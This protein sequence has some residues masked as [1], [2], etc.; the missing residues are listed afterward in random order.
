MAREPISRRKT[1]P[2]GLVRPFV[3]EAGDFAARGG[4]ELLKANV[5]I[6]A[7]TVGASLDGVV[8]GDYPWRRR[9]GTQI[10]RILHS[11]NYRR[12][13]GESAAKIFLAEGIAEWEPRATIETSQTRIRRT[14]DNRVRLQIAFNEQE[15]LRGR[16]IAAGR[17]TDPAKTEVVV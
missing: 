11:N 5:R 12:T 2:F 16:D 7:S 1:L 9:F 8:L 4:R 6:V 13:V 3:R 14:P 17:D 15:D 10:R